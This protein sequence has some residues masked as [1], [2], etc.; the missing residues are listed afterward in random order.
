MVIF[1]DH[2][3][4]AILNKIHLPEGDSEEDL[5][6]IAQ[7]KWE[8]FQPVDTDKKKTASHTAKS[9]PGVKSRKNAEQ[10]KGLRRLLPRR[11]GRIA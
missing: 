4:H 10:T 8:Q 6:A 9:E 1:K 2:D 7:G 5:L 3:I 11:R